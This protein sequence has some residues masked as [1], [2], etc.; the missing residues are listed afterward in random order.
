LAVFIASSL[1]AVRLG[2]FLVFGQPL[3]AHQYCLRVKWL[4]QI[5]EQVLQILTHKGRL[6]AAAVTSVN[7]F[8]SQDSL[9]EAATGPSVRA[10]DDTHYDITGPEAAGPLGL[11]PDSQKP[12]DYR[13]MVKSYG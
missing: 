1:L 9:A 4:L 13:G 11:P 7:S 8:Y 6:H 3:V 12:P 2:R 10:A 5:L